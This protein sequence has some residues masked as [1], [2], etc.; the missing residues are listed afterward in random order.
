[1]TESDIDPVLDIERGAY[2]RPWVREHFEKELDN[3]IAYM[4]SLTGKHKGREVFAGY[5]VFWVVYGEAHILNLTIAK[6]FRR[7]GL[8]IYVMRK[9]LDMMKASQVDDVFLEVRKSNVPAKE[10]Y[11]KLNF[12][13]SYERKKY[14]GDEDAVIMRLIF[15]EYI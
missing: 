6:A 8:G 15:N 11:R 10:L 5:V 14:Y 1:M 13:E 2:D 7:Q 4:Y 3:H 9:V 12:K